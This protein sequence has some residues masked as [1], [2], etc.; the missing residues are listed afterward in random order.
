MVHLILTLIA[1]ALSASL[2]I[3]AVNYVPWFA[4][5]AADIAAVTQTGLLRIES[6]HLSQERAAGGD[7]LVLPPGTG[8]QAFQ[9]LLVDDVLRFVPAA[10]PGYGWSLHQKPADASAYSEL[11]YVC[12]S[13][14]NASMPLTKPIEMGLR[15]AIAIFP[16]QQAILASTCGATVTSP[17]ATV[18]PVLSFYLVP[19]PPF[20]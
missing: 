8:A 7:P 10:P 9:S 15:Q 14:T 1:I 16:P 2:S 12:L 5:P 6:A 13:P 20:V 3:V 19:S 4:K 17:P 18:A 11:L